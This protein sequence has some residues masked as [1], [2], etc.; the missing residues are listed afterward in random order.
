MK[1]HKSYFLREGLSLKQRLTGLKTE[2]RS[3]SETLWS[4]NTEDDE[5][6]KKETNYTQCATLS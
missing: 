4:G 6:S 3:I 1:A 2:I 5:Q